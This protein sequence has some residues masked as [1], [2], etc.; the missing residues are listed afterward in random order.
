MKIYF[1]IENEDDVSFYETVEDYIKDTYYSSHE[2]YNHS[3]LYKIEDKSRI[4]LKPYITQKILT[5]EEI[6][7][8]EEKIDKLIETQEKEDEYIRNLIKSG[9]PVSY[10]TGNMII[11]YRKDRQKYIDQWIKKES[12]KWNFN[13]N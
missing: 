2:C 5:E 9:K 11:Y 6:K 10:S 8:I 3:R 4:D 13:L 7:Q 1:S 12:Y